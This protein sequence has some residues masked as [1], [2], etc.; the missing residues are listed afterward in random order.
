MQIPIRQDCEWYL[1]KWILFSKQ[2][3]FIKKKFTKMISGTHIHWRR[4]QLLS[5][6]IPTSLASLHRGKTCKFSYPISSMSSL[7]SRYFGTQFSVTNTVLRW[8]V[9]LQKDKCVNFTLSNLSNFRTVFFVSRH[10]I[11]FITL[12]YKWESTSWHM[13]CFNECQPNFVGKFRNDIT[14][15]A[16]FLEHIDSKNQFSAKN[17]NLLNA[18]IWDGM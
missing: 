9:Q 18:S 12:F 11:S 10:K 3:D 17:Q 6:I 14:F 16:N 4:C 8:M 7:I 5:D 13:K 1:I 2:V 15:G